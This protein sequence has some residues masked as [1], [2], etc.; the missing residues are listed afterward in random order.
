MSIRALYLPL[1]VLSI[2]GCSTH[3]SAKTDNADTAAET[4][5]IN[6][7]G[8]ENREDSAPSL[9]ANMARLGQLMDNVERFWEMDSMLAQSLLWMDEAIEIQEA[10]LL[11][12]PKFVTIQ[13][14]HLQA[15]TQLEYEERLQESIR[16]TKLMK[17][18]MEA[19][20]WASGLQYY[21]FLKKNMK[22]SHTIFG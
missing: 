3:Q 2:T 20:E 16:L 7:T 21:K 15:E 22:D 17:S 14:P 9:A 4:Q 19:K 11:Q 1:L 8:K 13:P 6:Q 12:T 5:L 10:C 18:A